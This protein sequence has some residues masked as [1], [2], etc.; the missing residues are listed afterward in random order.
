MRS[1]PR[2]RLAGVR[3]AA[4]NADQSGQYQSL[5]EPLNQAPRSIRWE[6]WQ[7]AL[8]HKWIESQKHGCDLGDRAVKDWFRKHW[9]P[10]CRICRLEHVE[11]EQRW[12]E[13]AE[14]EFGQIS[15]LI[16]NGDLLVD[17]ILDRME[18]GLDNLEVINWAL[19]WSMPIGRVID[20][21]ELIDIN[22]ARL[23]PLVG[24]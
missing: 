19:S 16:L 21:L 24:E 18:H 22:R 12:E 17:C 20:L 3:S 6:G 5:V 4:V 13:F 10:F 9:I 7:E 15:E 11:G 2:C 1:S 14:H 23:E 8:R